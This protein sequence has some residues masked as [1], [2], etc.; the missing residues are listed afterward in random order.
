M[1]PK[2]MKEELGIEREEINIIENLKVVNKLIYENDLIPL[3]L[4][5]KCLLN[6]HRLLYCGKYI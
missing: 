2:E 5:E 4:Q 3:P 6:S 1:S